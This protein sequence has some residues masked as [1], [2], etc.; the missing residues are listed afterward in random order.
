[1]MKFLL[2]AP[3]SFFVR[4]IERHPQLCAGQL[5]TPLTSRTRRSEIWALD[6]GCFNSFD[7]DE[8]LRLMEREKDARSSCLF[9]CCPDVVGN[10]R[11][12]LESF[13]SWWPKLG[14]WPICLVAQDG[15]EDMRIPW[16]LL[17]A[18]FIGGST[19]WKDSQDAIDVVKTAKL[20][21]VH[22]HVGRVNT[23]KRFRRFEEAG[24]DTCDGS[25]VSRFDW[26]L[27]SIAAGMADDQ[28]SIFDSQGG[29]AVS[30]GEE[31]GELA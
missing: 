14:T 21:G 18:I 29:I 27:D 23:I 8:F 9:V 28:P 24:A 4:A 6:N 3:E 1:M 13:E 5:I 12:T 11:R 7:R 2:D 16:D 31:K 26:M 22:A 19:C 17:K 10:A 25:G 20:L 30:C 15:I